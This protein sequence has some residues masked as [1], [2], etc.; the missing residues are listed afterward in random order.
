MTIK[1]IAA[2]CHEANLAYCDTHCDF[3]QEPWVFAPSWQQESAINGVV[4]AIDNP[5][6][7]PEDSHNNWLAQKKAD[8]WVWGPVKDV[9][10][11]KHPCLLPYDQLPEF[12]R[13]KDHLFQAIARALIPYLE[14][15]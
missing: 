10:A 1:D 6:S 11:K 4:F 3:S 15:K 5:D 12:Q 9:D 8:G 13:A 7:K 14:N 2:V